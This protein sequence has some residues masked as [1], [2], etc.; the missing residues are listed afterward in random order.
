MLA[1]IEKISGTN[2]PLQLVTLELFNMANNDAD[3]EDSE[4]HFIV[5]VDGQLEDDNIETEEAVNPAGD[6]N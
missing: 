3:S 5:D 4:D 2:D 6:I 1:Y